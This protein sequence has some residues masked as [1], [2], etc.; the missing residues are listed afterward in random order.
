MNSD[1]QP[2]LIGPTQPSVPSNR[3]FSRQAASAEPEV[4]EQ[5]AKLAGLLFGAESSGRPSRTKP[6]GR[7]VS[8]LDGND[9][10]NCRTAE[11]PGAKKYYFGLLLAGDSKAILNSEG[12]SMKSC[13]PFFMYSA[14]DAASM[15]RSFDTDNGGQ[16]LIQNCAV[17]N[18]EAKGRACA[19]PCWW[20]WWQFA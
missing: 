20:W 10:I 8:V 5:R 4:D 19:F 17:C 1:D 2:D 9:T 16:Q 6:S 12:L 18:S 7:R 13:F 3:A 14:L 11:T 15:L